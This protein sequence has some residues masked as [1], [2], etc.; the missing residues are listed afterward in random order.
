M[1]A[2]SVISRKRSAGEASTSGPAQIERVAWLGLVQPG[3]LGDGAHRFGRLAALQGD[4][5][6]QM[7][8]C[9]LGRVQR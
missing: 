6:E 2:D 1:P 4:Q 3:S 8:G 7:Q 5:A 9:G